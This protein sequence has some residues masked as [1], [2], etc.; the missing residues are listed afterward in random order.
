MNPILHF[1][2]A[3]LPA[4]TAGTDA[5]SVSSHHSL[6]PIE[7]T[8]TIKQQ[9]I[10]FDQPLA[11]NSFNMTRME[12]GGITT[13][14]DFSLAT[15]NLYMPDY[16]SRMTSTIY[17]RGIGARME[18][19]S[20]GLYLDNVPIL[21][22]NNYEFDFYDIRRTDILRGP[23]CTLYGRNSIGGVINIFTLSPLDFQ[24]VRVYAGYG[25]GNTAD[26]RA[27]VYRRETEHF[28]WS[29]AVG[30]H[31]S[32]GFFTNVYDGSHADKILSEG[33]RN[34][35]QWK[36]SERLFI[37]N[38][39][40]FNYVKQNGFA[41]A[42]I[43]PET[44]TVGEVN[45]N[46]PCKYDRTGII[47]GTTVRYDGA[48]FRF[49]SVTSYQYM[50]DRMTMDQDF[51]PISM[52]TLVQAQK[53][54]A[55]TQELLFRSIDDN[56]KW[57]WL[58]GAFGFYK[59]NRM[60]A[61][62]T[63][64]KDGIDELIVANTNKYMDPFYPGAVMSVQEEEFVISSEF[65]LPT[66]GFAAFHQSSVDLGRWRLTA[67]VRF[68]YEHVGLSSDNSSRFHYHYPPVGD[69]YNLL[70]SE[71][72]TRESL[73]Y[74]EILPKFSAMYHFTH[75]NLY[76]T[77][78]RGY[79][80]GGVNTQ[81]FSEV[82]QS[83]M[84]NDLIRD[85][86]QRPNEQHIDIT[87]EPESNW[88]YEAGAHLNLWENRLQM[89]VAGFYIDSRNQQIT[90]FPPGQSTGR[91]MSNAGKSRS[92]G[93]EITAGYNHNGL[94]VDLSYGF[95]DARFVEYHDNHT[96]HKGNKVPYAPR[97]T[98]Y[99]AGEYGIATGTGFPDRIFLRL[100]WR[101]AGKMYWNEAN[102]MSQGFY[103]LIGAGLGFKAGNYYLDLWGRNLTGKKYNTFYFT[104]IG[105]SFVQKAKPRQYG[106][107][108]RFNL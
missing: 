60:D 105:N 14:K 67:G 94:R 84:R 33:I 24:G 37:D 106:A 78:T 52:F 90:V 64:K 1:L 32:D 27:S 66:Y 75:G 89:V 50:N 101:G 61:P 45:H 99:A 35:L 77:V 73:S 28:G 29:L 30:H 49:Q 16:G 22:K 100:D 51:L 13:Q 8:A 31:S 54:H 44:G 80:A 3:A 87:Y 7:V 96:D 103:G 40:S 48:R 5:D 70:T 9:G 20:M 83:R 15:P 63:F 108:L 10:L 85:L 86:G 59:H 17:V 53:E 92:Y 21:N 11:G 38:T 18:Q 62:V 93:A 23:Q 58:A 46:D 43:D 72:N 56:R 79:K 6:A 107:T 91:M 41:Y 34:R 12:S 71:M 69:G 74:L 98:V 36:L 42:Y 19:P 57:Q 4:V 104:S 65:K 26:V 68:D 95:T 2:I 25:N 39:L 82:L 47:N 97:N 76:A 81:I 102:T 88:N 55:V